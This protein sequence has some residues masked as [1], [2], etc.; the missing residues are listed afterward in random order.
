MD[1]DVDYLI[2]YS[3]PVSEHVQCGV[4]YKSAMKC[5]QLARVRALP[6]CIAETRGS[7]QKVNPS[8]Y[9]FGAILFMD[10]LN[11]GPPNIKTYPEPSR[12]VKAALATYSFLV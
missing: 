6:L 12:K 11:I 2:P 3:M 9:V 10:N 8:A 1:F 7:L 4:A 5:P